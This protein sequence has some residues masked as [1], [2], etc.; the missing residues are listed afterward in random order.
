MF[1][2]L[3]LEPDARATGFPLN[4]KDEL[5]TDLAMAASS[6]SSAS[7]TPE[8]AQPAARHRR[9]ARARSHQLQRIGDAKQLDELRV[10]AERMVVFYRWSRARREG[11]LWLAR[12]LGALQTRFAPVLDP[13]VRADATATALFTRLLLPPMRADITAT[14][15][16][17]LLLPPPV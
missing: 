9:R 16:S 11:R 6:S 5:V 7:V 4:H 17:A 8:A 12:R 2:C 13:P 1:E 14:A 3:P 15:L 10:L